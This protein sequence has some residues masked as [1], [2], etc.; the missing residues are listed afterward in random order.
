MVVVYRVPRSVVIEAKLLRFK[1]PKFIAL[2]NILL[3]RQLVPELVQDE[4]TPATVRAEL[5]ALLSDG[6]ER[7]RQLQGF[8]EL[9]VIL[10]PDDAITRTAEL[11]L[12]LV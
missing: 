12:T 5:D 11:A 3:D 10:G 8:E 7:A 9:D 6:E 2:P 1:R 4:A